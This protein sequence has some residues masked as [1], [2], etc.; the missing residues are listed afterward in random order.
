[1]RRGTKSHFCNK[2]LIFHENEL[3]QMQSSLYAGIEDIRKSLVVG[4]IGT[5]LEIW[6]PQ[7]RWEHGVALAKQCLAERT[8]HSMRNNSFSI[9]TFVRSAAIAAREYAAQHG[10]F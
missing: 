7:Q 9:G 10:T 4:G 3:L 8:S 5:R 2:L 1:M 6:R